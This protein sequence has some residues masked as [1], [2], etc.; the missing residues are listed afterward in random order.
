MN[1]A[2]KTAKVADGAQVEEGNKPGRGGGGAGMKGSLIETSDAMDR[3][4]V[5]KTQQATPSGLSLPQGVRLSVQPP[6]NKDRINDLIKS[7]QR[8][9]ESPL[10]T[11]EVPM[12]LSRAQLLTLSRQASMLIMK[13]NN[14]LDLNNYNPFLNEFQKYS[15]NLFDFGDNNIFKPKEKSHEEI[16]KERLMRSTQ[17]EYNKTAKQLRMKLKDEEISPERVEQIM[18]KYP[19]FKADAIP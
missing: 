7:S 14:N 18:K 2:R 19:P 11:N 4:T 1:S 9:D 13:E 5:C 12:Q 3:S 8:R 6:E 17:N 15:S 10:R 16:Q